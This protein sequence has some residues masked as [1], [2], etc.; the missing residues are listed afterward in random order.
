LFFT[1]SF[2][3]VKNWQLGCQQKTVLAVKALHNGVPLENNVNKTEKSY[4]KAV[5]PV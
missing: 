4:K 3:T 2:F 5:R 1:A